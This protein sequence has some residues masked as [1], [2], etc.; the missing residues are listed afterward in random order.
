[1]DIITAP[2]QEIKKGYYKEF[3]HIQT[4][5]RLFMCFPIFPEFWRDFQGRPKYSRQIANSVYI[6]DRVVLFG[7]FSILEVNDVTNTKP[8]SVDYY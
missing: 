8:M 5:I 3:H 2:K 7:K 6:L 1:M 4:A